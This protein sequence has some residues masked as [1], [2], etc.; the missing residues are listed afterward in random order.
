M[1]NILVIIP[2]DFYPPQFG[3]A[4]RCYYLL[5]EYAKN[6]HVFLLTTH[7]SAAFPKNIQTDFWKNITVLSV[8]EAEKIKTVFNRLPKRYANATSTLLIQRRLFKKNNQFLLDSY[9]ILKKL[10]ATEKIDF[11]IYEN[12]ECFGAL[13]H[14][15]RRTDPLV[16][17]IY[18]AH[19]IDSILWKA[20][21]EISGSTQC[22]NYSKSA[23][24]LEKKLYKTTSLCFCCSEKDKHELDKLNNHQA[25]IVVI[26]NG[27]DTRSKP[28][29][30][31]PR[32]FEKQNILFCGTLDYGPNME[33]VLWFYKNIFP[34]IKKKLPDMRFTVV[35]RMNQQMAYEQLKQ[36]S[37]VDFLGPVDCVENYYRESAVLVVPLLKGSG[38]RL[39]ILEAL[40][41][42]TPVVSTS[43]GSEG[44]EIKNGRH[45]IIAD[46]EKQFA[47]SIIKL[48]SNKYLYNRLQ[49]E[50]RKVAELKYDWQ[51]IG[52]KVQSFLCGKEN[53]K[54][55]KLMLNDKKKL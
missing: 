53:N 54:S 43:Y 31:N 15:I 23:L 7:L 2:Y 49:I 24:S 26:P 52:E 36:D 17:H 21:A 41:F 45:L 3:G 38:T 50:G 35:G 42:G 4:L 1:A 22:L 12:L 20:Q 27:V 48:I 44:L 34:L 9:L 29:D 5:K 46:D 25:N 11:V 47:I 18:D 37:S 32:K 30:C 13:S 14:F 40:S 55:G 51:I 6:N 28:F 8:P 16:K 39:K 10:L 19:N 33:G